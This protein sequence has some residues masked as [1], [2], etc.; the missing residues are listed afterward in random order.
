MG[1]NYHVGLFG[2]VDAVFFKR[3]ITVLGQFV[4]IFRSRK[5]KRNIL[6]ILQRLPLYS[7]ISLFITEFIPTYTCYNIDIP[8]VR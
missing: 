6:C 4:I 5:K 3:A 8:E 2:D 7:V 1:F